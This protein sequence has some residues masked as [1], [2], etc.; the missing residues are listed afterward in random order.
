MSVALA[1]IGGVALIALIAAMIFAVPASTER[2][3]RRNDA[4]V[5]PQGSELQPEDRAS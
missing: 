2:V 5:D 3:R 1:I 4:H